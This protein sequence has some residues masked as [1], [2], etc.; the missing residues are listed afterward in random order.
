MLPGMSHTGGMKFFNR[1]WKVYEMQKYYKHNQYPLLF[2]GYKDLETHG[3]LVEKYEYRRL[4]TEIREMKLG[5]KP[6]GNQGSS[7]SVFE[8][9]KK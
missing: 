3:N 9:K 4:R 2:P 6:M 8:M 7:M 5:N 1:S